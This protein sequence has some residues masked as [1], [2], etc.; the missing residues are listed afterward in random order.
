MRVLDAIREERAVLAQALKQ[1]PGLRRLF[2]DDLYPDKAHF[3]YELLQN[4]EDQH[5]TE[6]TFQLSEE[7][8][9]FEHNGTPFTEADIRGITGFGGGLK[10]G[11]EDKI[12]RFGIGFKA[13]FKYTNTPR[14]WSPTYNFEIHDLVVPTELAQDPNIGATTRFEFPFDNPLKPSSDAA[15]E[16][17]TGLEQL[18]ETTLL[19]LNHISSI[20]WQIQSGPSGRVIRVDRGDGHI[21][22][23]KLSGDQISASAHF[24]RFEKPI[25]ETNGQRAAIAF[26]IEELPSPKGTPAT[27]P[28]SKR[29]R[30]VPATPGRVAIYF[31]ADKEVSGLRFHLHAPFVPELSRASVKDSPANEPLFKQLADLSVA[32]LFA[33]RDRGLLDADFLAVLPNPRE[34]LPDRYQ[35]IRDGIIDAL[36]NQPLTPTQAKKHAPAK[37]LRQASAALKTLLSDDD[38]EQLIAYEDSPPQWVVNA[39]Q[40]NSDAD[41]LLSSLGIPNW[42]INDFILKL[43][44]VH[45]YSFQWVDGAPRMIKGTPIQEWLSGH[46]DEWHQRL[47]ALLYQEL[48]PKHGLRRVRDAC[49]VRTGTGEYDVGMRSF[50]ATD[51]VDVDPILPRVRIATY[52]SGRNA[53][54]KSDARKFLEGVGVREV[55]ETEQVEA[56]L[57]QRYAETPIRINR[58]TH[59]GD[60]KRFIALVDTDYN[61]AKMFAE[62]SV[63]QL[64]DGSWGLPGDVYLDV[65]YVATGLDVFYSRLGDQTPRQA[66]SAK[67]ARLD[68]P[69][70]KIAQFAKA[71][72]AVTTLEISRISCRRNPEWHTSLRFAPGSKVTA[73]SIDRDYTIVGLDEA[74]EDPGIELS[75]LVWTSMTEMTA[76]GRYLRA[77]YRMNQ[78][79]DAR[80]ASSQL[81]YVLRG[82]AW[83]PQGEHEFLSPAEATQDRLPSGFPYDPGWDWLQAVGFGENRANQESERRQQLSVARQWGIKTEEDLAVI[84]RFMR[85][86]HDDRVWAMSQLETR[87][88]RHDVDL[89]E[90]EPSQ[91]ERRAEKV[92]TEAAQAPG[93]V[94]ELRMRSVSVERESVKKDTDPYLRMQYTNPDDELICQI[95]K[96]AMPFRLADGNHYFAAVEFLPDLRRRHYQNYLALCPNHAAMYQHANDAPDLVRRAF[97][98]LTDN[99]MEIVLAGEDFSIYFTRTHALDL[100]AI[101]A[102]DAP[103]LEPEGEDPSPA[104]TRLPLEEA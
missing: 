63:F 76:Q 59:T 78:S 34:T 1:E 44:Q 64:A 5:A 65:P 80:H 77:T 42:D 12:G 69:R 56:I 7:K 68:I 15:Q 67:Y 25:E 98:E 13:V 41:R 24:L 75:R 31:P 19:F 43:V 26:A 91:P 94:T 39:P 74:L 45:G 48:A 88:E 100:Q 61:T 73:T 37:H 95:C 58:T 96:S 33:V 66:L 72:G 16:V 3:I 86:S 51:D 8:L 46:S 30:V 40:R 55:G 6:V 18:S 27:S 36:I 20:H 17:L 4:A 52:T 35:I 57:K 53:A 104:D 83:V 97:D 22:T 21:E 29:Y 2:V 103:R 84:T 32:A 87:R 92:A 60:L 62:Y 11:R 38:L 79:Y 70:Q 23:Q 85:H 101:V 102:I 81:V 47:Y 71:V 9:Q 10:A 28:N 54:Q 14:I 50:F 90:H 99:T 89:P 82:H 93:R 49:I